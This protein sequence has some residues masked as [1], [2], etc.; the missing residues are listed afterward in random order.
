MDIEQARTRLK[1]FFAGRILT[2]S[3]THYQNGEW[4]AEC[5][6]IPAIVTGGVDTDI[7]A[8]DTKM[9][10]AILVAA[11]I[12]SYFASLLQFIG[13]KPTGILARIFGIDNSESDK[14]A[15]YVI[16]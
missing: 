15:K 11:G 14:E 6:E 5:N 3:I 1:T 4:V 8:M 10:D 13:Y 12:D 2:F 9:R 16:T 7:T